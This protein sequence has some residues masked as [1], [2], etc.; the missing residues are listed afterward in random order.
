MIDFNYVYQFMEAY[1]HE[2]K[3]V[4]FSESDKWNCLILN[5]EVASL[6]S[7]QLHLT[8][9]RKTNDKIIKIKL[10]VFSSFPKS[11]FILFSRYSW[12][13]PEYKHILNWKPLR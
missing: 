9:K 8:A 5:Y 13:L 1:L 6:E 11:Y 4:L 2:D 7:K 12:S 10:L 3:G